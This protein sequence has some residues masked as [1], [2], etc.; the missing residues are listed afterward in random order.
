MAH[1][2]VG[3]RRLRDRL[4]VRLR[5]HWKPVTALG[6]G[7]AAMV[8]FLGD[9]RIT[10]YV[11]SASQV[12]ADPITE[13]VSGAVD[14]FDRT[15]S[16][17][18]QLTYDETDFAK[19]MK[20]FQ[21]DG[22]KEYIE[23]DLV[24]DGVSLDEVG[25]RLKGNSTL[26]S[27]RGT[28]GSPGGGRAEP[29]AAQGAP[30]GAEGTTGT[31]AGETT[32]AQ[33]GGAAGATG[34]QETAGGQTG[35]QGTGGGQTGGQDTGRGQTEGGGQTGGADRGGGMVSY[36][37]SED[38]PEELPWLIKIDEYVEGR[39]YQGRR[40]ISLRPGSDEQ[41]PLNEALSLSLTEESGRQSERF[42]FT[43]VAVNNRPSVTRLIVENPDTDYADSLGDGVL[44]K[45]R[46]GGSFDYQG[47]DPT[48]Y[49]SS[50][51]QLNKKGSQ[52]L[53]PVMKLVK[54]VNNASDEEFERDLDE[55]VDVDSLADY[56]ATQN[57]LMNGD[58][59]AGPGKNY[60]LWYDLETKKFSVLGWDYN[61][62]FSGDTTAGPDDTFSLGGGGGGG[63]AGGGG[64]GAKD[65]TGTVPE[66]PSGGEASGAPQGVPE[67]M[68]S[69]MPQG[70]PDGAM[71]GQGDTGGEGQGATGGGGRGGGFSSGH[72]LKERFLESDA[73]DS[74]YKKAYRTLYQKLYKSGTAV[75]SLQS[76]T[77]A[78]RKA[79]ADT[80][81]L[82]TAASTLKQTVT[83]R[84][85]ALAE[86]SQVVG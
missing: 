34:G 72:I 2:A 6:A 64:Q 69:G 1:T 22:T 28:S 39:A 20:E 17:S 68:P 13:N 14:L 3:G 21:D 16:H 32:G 59:M 10:P 9:A 49:E 41:V 47:D 42:G 11:T 18:I 78:A 15:V 45:A 85:K 12:E 29:N 67:G 55:Y 60:L 81:G 5:H 84:T 26:M 83:Q 75:E 35:G 74:V 62:T 43:S 24:I 33:P 54:W 23:A 71:G 77:E 63:G 48:D 52:D 70:M 56:V 61:L 82:D 50:F 4:P 38:R 46:A 30:P 31:E 53:E 73:F 51:K 58:D 19:M 65:G 76:I 66:A 37:L 57:L 8:F 25:I 7:L 79:G 40:E 80:E 86:D 27:L 36:D 44:Y